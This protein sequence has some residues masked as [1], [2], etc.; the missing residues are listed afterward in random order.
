M[1]KIGIAVCFVLC[2]QTAWAIT[3]VR[4]LEG[5]TEYRLDN[6]LVLLLTP[7][8]AKPTTTVNLTYRVGSRH[9]GYGE[10]G[11]AHLLE[12][13][14][15]KPS[16]SVANPKKELSNRGVRWNA[17]TSFDRTNYFAQF[18]SQPDTTD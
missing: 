6:G 10:T 18:A 2:L 8:N 4:Q 13:M 3:K 14:L 7:D 16:R 9:E 5:I 11:T 17:T 12:H 1:V 15:F